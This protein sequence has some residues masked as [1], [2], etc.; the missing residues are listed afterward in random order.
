MKREE[1]ALKYVIHIFS[2]KCALFVSFLLRMKRMQQ[3][4]IDICLKKD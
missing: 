3:I 4:I 2:V 1:K